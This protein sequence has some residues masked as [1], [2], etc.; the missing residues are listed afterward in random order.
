MNKTALSRPNPSIMRFVERE[1]PGMS[2]Y[3]CYYGILLHQ[4]LPP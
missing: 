2:M 3:L 4:E 1:E